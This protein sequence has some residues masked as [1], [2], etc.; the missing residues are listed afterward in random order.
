MVDEDIEKVFGEDLVNWERF[1]ER[2]GDSIKD[3]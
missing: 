3:I 1:K 2:Y